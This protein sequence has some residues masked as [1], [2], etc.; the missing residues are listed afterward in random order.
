MAE[1]KG[2][3]EGLITEE[4]L[5][6]LRGLD[7]TKLRINPMYLNN[8]LASKKAIRAFANGLGDI[9]PL[10]RDEDYARNSRYGTIVAP[11]SWTY[12]LF[13]AGIM[14]GLPG[15]HSFHA[16]DDWEFYKPILLGDVTTPEA[17]ARGYEELPSRFAARMLKQ[18]Q[19]RQYYNQ[20]GELVAKALRWNMRTERQS[21][22]E[23]GKYSNIQLP[24]PWT[25]SELKNVE[26]EVL[27]E[28]IR[29][30]EVRCWEDVNVGDELP[31]LVKGPHSL[32]AEIAWHAGT[33][34][35]LAAG[36][37]SLRQERLGHPYG[38]VQR[39]D[40]RPGRVRCDHLREKDSESRQNSGKLLHGIPAAIRF[41]RQQSLL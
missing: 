23:K 2:L 32:E 24:H 41:R 15:V 12:S 40:Y 8:D 22:R 3:V 11:P 20:R 7:G 25:E 39:L 26:D 16:G 9:N 35:F 17:I 34:N 28:V 33:V 10:W 36:G 19:E 38:N 30:S 4:G 29:G 18:Y 31:Q 5:K 6:Q 14:H 37:V 27:A 1:E 21:A 13:G